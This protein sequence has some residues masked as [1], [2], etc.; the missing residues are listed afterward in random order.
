MYVCMDVCMWVCD[1][2][3]KNANFVRQ[4]AVAYLLVAAAAAA[5]TACR[6]IGYVR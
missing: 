4:T 3:N 1:D 6:F 5:A 2:E